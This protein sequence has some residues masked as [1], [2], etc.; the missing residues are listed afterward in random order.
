ML[1]VLL[2]PGFRT[3]DLEEVARGLLELA[4]RELGHAFDV[5]SAG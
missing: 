3:G 1:H 4:A 5:D 2:R